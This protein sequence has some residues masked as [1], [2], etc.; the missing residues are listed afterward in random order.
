MERLQRRE[1]GSGSLV[2][3]SND[4]NG[5]RQ[6]AIGAT[7]PESVGVK[8]TAVISEAARDIAIM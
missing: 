4:V 3:P 1:T 2:T 7:R 5:V 8:K 6:R